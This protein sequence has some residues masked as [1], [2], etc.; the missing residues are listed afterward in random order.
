VIGGSDFVEGQNGK[1]VHDLED[2]L[3]L[4]TT[5]L[6][7]QDPEHIKEVKKVCRDLSRDR[8]PEEGETEDNDDD[9]LWVQEILC[10]AYCAKTVLRKMRGWRVQ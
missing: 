7:T 2:L 9:D 10:K 3:S 5:A 4:C 6:H 8:E 1:Q